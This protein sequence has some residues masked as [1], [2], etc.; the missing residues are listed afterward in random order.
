MKTIVWDVDDVLNDLMRRWFE[1]KWLQEHAGCT[2]S[3]EMI[4]ENPP[5]RILGISHD[6]Y[7]YSLDSFRLSAMQQLLP[8]PEVLNWFNKYG[9]HFRHIAL[10]ANPFCAAS[11][12][13]EW[14]IRHFGYWIRSFNFVPSMRK[15][16][17]ENIYD[18]TKADY[19]CWWGKADFFVD[20]NPVHVQAA[21]EIGIT[22]FLMPRPWNSNPSSITETLESLVALHSDF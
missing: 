3:Y 19:L 17:P 9:H 14:V 12:S 1:S 11:G 7:L 13:A 16:Q 22:S 15:T 8:V 20:D 2:V 18:L 21:R 6:E 10:T 5:D 4:V